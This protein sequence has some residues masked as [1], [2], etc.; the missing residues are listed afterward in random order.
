MESLI[1]ISIQFIL[2]F[3]QQTRKTTELFGRENH[4]RMGKVAALYEYSLQC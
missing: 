2:Y 1:Y 3:E 4:F